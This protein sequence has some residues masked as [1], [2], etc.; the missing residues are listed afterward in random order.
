[1]RALKTI[2]LAALAAATIGAAPAAAQSI[3]AIQQRGKIVIGMDQTIPPYGLT[4]TNMQPTGYD[5]D[6]SNAIAQALGVQVEFV[7]VAGP[8]RIPALL[9]NQVDIIVATLSMSPERANQVW[10]SIPYGSVD[11]V[12]VAA[13][14]KTAAGAPDFANMRVG[15]VRGGTQDTSFTPIADPSTEIVR[16][17]DDATV[18]QALL[19]GQ[20]DAVITA[21]QWA[22]EFIKRNESA[23]LEIKFTVRQS[24]YGIGVRKGETDILQWMN[25][26]VAFL[27]FSGQ[28][29]TIHRKWIGSPLPELPVW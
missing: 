17:D 10:F 7:Q 26:F 20:V 27:K 11:V 16:F 5:A 22:A 18:G 29:D 24:P 21:S 25:E 8:G 28:L 6:V 15:V 3:E 23:N 4:D 9:T 1:M 14:D 19:S 12:A 13:K 2:A